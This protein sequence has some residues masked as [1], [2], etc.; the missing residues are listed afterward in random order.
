MR[1]LVLSDNFPP[2]NPGGAGA[3]AAAVAQRLAE[4]GHEIVVVTYGAADRFGS[5]SR[6]RT[7]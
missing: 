2:A 1:I 6:D 4:W 3:V 5:V 7:A